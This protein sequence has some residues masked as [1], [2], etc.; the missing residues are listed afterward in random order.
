MAFFFLSPEVIAKAPRRRTM[1][2]SPYVFVLMATLR[3]NLDICCDTPLASRHERKRQIFSSEAADSRA[4][5]SN[6]WLLWKA[7]THRLL[8]LLFLNC[9]CEKSDV[10]KRIRHTYN[11][12]RITGISRYIGCP[13][14]PNNRLDPTS[15]LLVQDHVHLRSIH[16]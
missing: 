5:R 11:F 15:V 1:S 16:T 7:Q 8:P 6:W 3:V 4:M 13:M 12:C 10:K 9:P 14:M 2:F